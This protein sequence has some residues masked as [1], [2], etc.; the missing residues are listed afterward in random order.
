LVSGGSDPN[1]N[2]SYINGVLTVGKSRLFA[3]ADGKSKIYGSANPVFTITYSGFFSGDDASML[4]VPPVASTNALSTS[5]AGTYAITLSGGSDHNYD[6]VLTNGVLTVEK[7][8]LTASADSK[9]RAYSEPNPDL[10]VS[11]TGFVNGQD[12]SVL[13]VQP[14]VTTDAVENS[15]AGTYDLNVSG[16]SDGNYSIMYNKGTLN[17]TKADQLITFDAIP[18]RLRMTQESRLAAS[19]TSGLPVIFETSDPAIAVVE[20]D[21]LK[22]KKEGHLTISAVQTGDHNWNAAQDVFQTIETLPTFDGISSLFTPNNDGMND[23][24]YIPELEQYGKLEVTV[25]NRFGQAVYRS[26][27]Y[28]NDWDGTWNGSPLPSA[29]YYYIIKSSAKGFIKGVVNIVR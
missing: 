4:D 23:Y 13:D 6:L 15:D 24:W 1:Y 16:A 28:R 22:V 20:G 26:D 10:T 29:S 8:I 9:S 5:D 17:I 7:V 14:V 21:M 3:L 11:Y 27:S 12:Q 25:Y 19:S 18:G 2:Y